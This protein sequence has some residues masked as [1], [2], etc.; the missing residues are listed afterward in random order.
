MGVS[1]EDQDYLFKHLHENGKIRLHKQNDDEDLDQ[2]QSEH[3]YHWQRKRF[4]TVT[5]NPE[6]GPLDWL[7]PKLVII[8]ECDLFLEWQK[9]FVEKYPNAFY[10]GLTGTPILNN[11][12][13]MGYPYES[14]VCAPPTSELIKLG[15]IVPA[16]AFVPFVPDLSNVPINSATKDYSKNVLAKKLDDKKLIGD[17]VA[18]WEK[19]GKDRQTIVFCISRQHGLHVHDQFTSKG[20]RFAYLDG[21]TPD[22]EREDIFAGIRDRSIQG[23]VSIMA[24]GRGVDL[25]ILSCAILLRPTRSLKLLLQNLG[26]VIRADPGSQKKD[27]LILDHSG[28]F[29]FHQITP[30]QDI[31]WS[32]GSD[33]NPGA[34]IRDNVENGLAPE[35]KICKKC[36]FAFTGSSCPECGAVQS[37]RKKKE[38]IVENGNLVEMDDDIKQQVTWE[39]K[40]KFWQSCLWKA[41]YYRNGMGTVAMARAIYQGKYKEWPDSGFQNS[42]PRD[43]PGNTFV[44]DIPALE[45]MKRKIESRMSHVG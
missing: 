28:A 26:R 24:I 12:K 14:L 7:D 1:Q 10:V 4:D 37:D 44:I 43:T 34:L 36:Q 16:R 31:E 6:E 32:L 42:I 41:A 23:I 33:A 21:D 20:Y 25:P 22:N 15:R 9:R 38:V 19:Y 11:G 3:V 13:A 17:A 30:N 40:N 18:H 45:F 35:L 39:Q 8:D 5:L 29:L 2:R 27:A